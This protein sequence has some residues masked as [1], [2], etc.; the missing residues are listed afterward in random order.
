[1]NGNM[2]LMFGGTFGMFLAITPTIMY[3][4]NYPVQAPQAA[5]GT[6]RCPESRL[7]MAGVGSG[8]RKRDSYPFTLK[9][10]TGKLQSPFQSHPNSSIVDKPIYSVKMQSLLI[11]AIVMHL[12]ALFYRSPEPGP[13]LDSHC[14]WVIRNCGCKGNC[15]G[16]PQ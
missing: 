1:M 16:R 6:A 10:E 13:S 9:Q 5:H 11:K 14:T 2:C 3:G 15:K 12:I 7:S 4:I 8:L